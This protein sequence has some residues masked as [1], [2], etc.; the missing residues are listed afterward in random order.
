MLKMN[1]EKKKLLTHAAT[2]FGGFLF[3][4][5]TGDPSL[6]KSLFG[7]RIVPAIIVSCAVAYTA[8]NFPKELFGYLKV[9][10]SNSTLVETKAID[11]GINIFDKN[12]GGSL[13]KEIKTYRGELE[14]IDGKIED[15]YK[16][17]TSQ[18]NSQQTQQKTITPDSYIGGLKDIFS[19]DNS[20]KISSSTGNHKD[21]SSLNNSSSLNIEYILFDKSDQ[22]FYIF[23]NEKVIHSGNMIFNR[24]GK[25]PNGVYNVDKIKSMT[26]DL[27]PG[28]ITLDGLILAI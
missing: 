20:E 15:L 21:N 22:K 6:R 10:D 18:Q 11:K 17:N 1:E 7:Y 3:G 5:M 9:S 8:I 14:R 19:T 24:F 16:I 12:N 13:E 23:S 2:A 26:G 4:R 25:P 28:F 27:Y